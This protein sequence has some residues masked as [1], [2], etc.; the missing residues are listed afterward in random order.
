MTTMTRVGPGTD[1]R[2]EQVGSFAAAIAL[3]AFLLFLVQ[4]MIGKW[5]LP[6]FGGSPAVWTTCMLF[7]QVALFAGYLYAHLSQRWLGPRGQAVVHLVLVVAALCALPLAPAAS[8]KPGGATAPTGRILQLLLASVG[9]PYF[10]LAATSPLVQAWFSRRHPGHSPY[11][12]YALSNVGS[13]AALLAYPFLVEPRFDVTEQ[14]WWWSVLFLVYAALCVLCLIGLWRPRETDAEEASGLTGLVEDRAA[15]PGLSRR[16]L[17]LLLPG[18]A[19]VVLLA[20][21]NHV[22]QNIAVIPFLWIVPL[23]LYLATFIIAFDHARW[24]VRG[25]WCP[26][27]LLAIVAVTWYD[28]VDFFGY[29]LNV[30]QELALYFGAMFLACMVCHGEAR[31][32]DRLLP[33]DRGGWCRRGYLRQRD[34]SACLPD[35]LRV[36]PGDADQLPHRGDCP[37]RDCRQR[38]RGPNPRR[39]RRDPDSARSLARASAVHAIDDPHRRL[40]EFLRYRERTRD[41]P[42]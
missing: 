11:R 17:W 4:P 7:F 40:A 13:L 39:D 38:T 41:R 23:I 34:C 33:D 12:L 26:A 15:A 30:R 14:S 16:L 25:F 21:T 22:C 35:L 3:G 27:A 28:R 20:T 36:A 6:W 1:R 9:L 2:P 24:Y 31:P 42:R 29:D 37:D 10:V 18:C 5:I 32:S 19:S 8:W